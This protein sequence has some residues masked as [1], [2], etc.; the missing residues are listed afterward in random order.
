M[1]EVNLGFRVRTRIERPDPALLEPFRKVTAANVTD[2]MGKTGVMDYRIYPVVMPKSTVV[3][4]A[5]TVRA[6][7]GDNLMICKAIMLCQ[8][9]DVLVVTSPGGTDNALWGGVLSTLAAKRGIAALV[10]DGLVRDVAEMRR[11]GVPIWAMG[12]LPTGPTFD[13]KGE[14]NTT[15]SCGGVV[16]N[17]GDVVV[18]DE[19]GV[20]VVPRELAAQ[21]GPKALGVDQRDANWIKEIEET[22]VFGSI[23][24]MEAILKEKGCQVEE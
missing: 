18:A 17:P 8:P 12:L 15:I 16:V 11:A 22:G 23:A 20:V 3:G 1:A 4:P 2:A 5:V 21:V 19:D 9:G 6:R 10:T 24:K 13:G 7:A 14:V